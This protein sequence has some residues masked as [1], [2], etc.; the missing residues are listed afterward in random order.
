MRKREKKYTPWYAIILLRVITILC[1][2]SVVFF[3]GKYAFSRWT[4][5]TVEKKHAMVERQLTGCAELVLY[6]MRYSDIITIKKRSAFSKA[7][8]IVRYSGIIR[9][10]VENIS[11]SDIVL[12]D[13]GRNVTVKIPPSVLLGNDIYGQEVF[14]EQ[15]RVFNRITTQEIFDE[16]DNAKEEAAAEILAEGLL[17]DADERAKLVVKQFLL[18][19]GFKSVTVEIK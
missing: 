12:S 16:I 6:K 8:S 13:D 15:Q 3:G 9:A 17:D 18:S 7:F 11:D 19:L 5:I 14:D 10:G 2:S 1:I 4:K